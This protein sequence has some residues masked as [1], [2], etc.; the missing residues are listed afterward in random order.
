[1]GSRLAFQNL[2]IRA[3]GSVRASETWMQSKRTHTCL[4]SALRTVTHWQP[5]HGS[6][7]L[8]QTTTNGKL[9]RRQMTPSP[10]TVCDLVCNVEHGITI[11]TKIQYL[12]LPDVACEPDLGQATYE[13]VEAMSTRADLIELWLCGSPRHQKMVPSISSS[14]NQ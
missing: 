1:M 4:L 10:S 13:L 8:E 3:N 14:Y 11:A 5:P 12:L 7:R 6:K 2:T 9:H